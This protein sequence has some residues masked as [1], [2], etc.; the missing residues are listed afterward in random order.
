MTPHVSSPI[1]ASASSS[2]AEKSP[3]LLVADPL[4]RQIAVPPFSRC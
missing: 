1:L 4:Y 2:T 3:W